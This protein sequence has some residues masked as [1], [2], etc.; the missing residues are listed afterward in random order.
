VTEE[1]IILSF[2]CLARESKKDVRVKPEHDREREK[3]EPEHDREKNESENDK[4]NT[5]HGLTICTQEAT[6]FNKGSRRSH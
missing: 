1:K 5:R 2:P 4:E 3:K 6:R